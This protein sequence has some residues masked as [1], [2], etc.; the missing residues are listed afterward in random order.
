MYTFFLIETFGKEAINRKRTLTSFT[1]QEPFEPETYLK[2]MNSGMTIV[3]TKTVLDGK[4]KN[5]KTDDDGKKRIKCQETP[6]ETPLEPGASSAIKTNVPE[7]DKFLDEPKPWPFKLKRLK[8]YFDHDHN[9]C[10]ASELGLNYGDL[11]PGEYAKYFDEK[12]M[13]PKIKLS[14][15]EWKLAFDSDYDS[16]DPCNP[17]K[18][19]PIEPARNLFSSSSSSDGPRSPPSSD[20]DLIGIDS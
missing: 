1:N 9:I 17:W 5:I 16:F 20:E 13:V 4:S 7:D 2:M 14:P 3:V 15:A 8:K 10:V 11:I 6:S 19:P 18:F 12:A